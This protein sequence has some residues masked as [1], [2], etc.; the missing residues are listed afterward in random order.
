VIL[1]TPYLVLRQKPILR[2]ASLAVLLALLGPA[3]AFAQDTVK[4]P[5]V[6]LERVEVP[7]AGANPTMAAQGAALLAPKNDVPP[8]L[9]DIYLGD[10]S[11][12]GWTTFPTYMWKPS[13]IA[14]YPKLPEDD[15]GRQAML[16][17]YK[18]TS[19]FRKVFKRGQRVIYI[20][21]YDFQ[22]ADGAYGAYDYLRR[23]STTVLTRGDASSED[24]SSISI[25]QGKTFLSTYGTAEDDDEAKE[26]LTKIANAAVQHMQDKGLQPGI[27]NRLPRMELVRGTEKIVMGP[28]SVRR[29]FPAPYLNS[30]SLDNGTVIGCVGDYAVQEP[31]KER[32]KLLI[33]SYRS[34][35]EAN[36]A[37]LNFVGQL[38]EA[39]GTDSASMA[40]QPII[41][42]KVGPTFLGIARKGSDIFLVAGAKKRFSPAILLR[43]VR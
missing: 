38:A 34:T 23:G 5:T 3:Y 16:R 18:L 7:I 42:V 24:D 6:N 41:V 2:G 35:Q 15:A 30:L 1:V 39:H 36:D 29:F 43:Q 13:P 28:Q 32:L 40:A 8:T 11:F 19:F 27:L 20:D 14:P 17:E 21:V 22:T 25:V 9:L 37:Y 31:A 33:L 10:L 26:V 4:T 12:P